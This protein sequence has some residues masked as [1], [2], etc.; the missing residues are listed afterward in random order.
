[1]ADI[2]AI[3][4]IWAGDRF[5]SR[6]EA[7]WAVFFNAAGIR[8]IYEPE[9]FY[10]I[11]CPG[12]NRDPGDKYLP[13]FYLPEYDIYAEVK[14]ER[15][16]IGEEVKKAVN[17][18]ANKFNRKVLLILPE[19]PNAGALNCG[20]W[21]LPIYYY[22]PLCGITGCRA[23]FLSRLTDK[24]KQIRL[25]TNFAVGC[26][27]YLNTFRPEW[28]EKETKAIADKDMPRNNEFPVREEFDDFYLID[29]FVKARQARFEH[30][31]SPEVINW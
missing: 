10:K 27:C 13:D 8:Y 14:G 2:Q 26:H 4:T 19:I 1:M 17:I 16:G 25:T 11:C 23:A 12:D 29:C 5:R 18:M 15:P 3:E 30:G 20:V 9:G 28:I 31:E 24:G 21:W 7:R 6:L 22:H